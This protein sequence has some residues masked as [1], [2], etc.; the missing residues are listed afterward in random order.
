VAFGQR[1]SARSAQQRK[2][3]KLH[4]KV[5]DFQMGENVARRSFPGESGGCVEG[6]RERIRKAGMG[7]KS[8]TVSENVAEKKS[9]TSAT[10]KYLLKVSRGTS[11]GAGGRTKLNS[12]A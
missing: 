2:C 3:T 10:E 1:A 12:L 11:G 7:F 6:L 4:I 8:L 5:P 9:R